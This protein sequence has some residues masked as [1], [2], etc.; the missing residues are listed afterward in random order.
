[1]NLCPVDLDADGIRIGTQH[2]R[3][4]AHTLDTLKHASGTLTLGIR[5]EFVRVVND[6]EPGAVKANV[7]RVQQ[8]GNYQLVTA[9]CDGHTFRAKLEPHLRVGDGA[10][11][12]KLAAAQTVFFSNDE[13]IVR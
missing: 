1:M 13:R 4:D 11:W 8:L 6:G 7:L 10:V 12:L 9:Q 3:L 5:P 2:V